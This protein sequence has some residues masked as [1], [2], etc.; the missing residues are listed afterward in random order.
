VVVTS[1]AYLLVLLNFLLIGA[2]P[3]IFFKR[4]TLNIRWFATATPFALAAAGVLAVWLDAIEPW[5]H[6][7]RGLVFVGVVLDALSIYLIG[8]T[9]GSH[10]I[11]LALW[12][13]DDDAPVEI[14]TWGPYGL[15]R[16]PFYSS[17]LAA[18]V[19]AACVAPS[20]I[21]VLTA[22][23]GLVAMA[24]TARREERRLLGSDLRTTYASYAA[25]TGRFV[26]GLGRLEAVLR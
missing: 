19:A 10:R 23:V 9:M 18:F 26:P 16:H 25:G 11:P 8:F 4:G 5:G 22:L 24:I 7:N 14:V 12:H 17:F 21:T 1:A 15:V 3:R 6:G 2:L 13:Q 20:P